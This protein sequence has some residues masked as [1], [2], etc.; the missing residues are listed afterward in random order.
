MFSMEVIRRQAVATH[1]HMQT[2]L[3]AYEMDTVFFESVFFS[4]EIFFLFS[5]LF[6]CVAEICT[7]ETDV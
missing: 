2:M 1:A 7:T 6:L 5:G 4:A 3:N